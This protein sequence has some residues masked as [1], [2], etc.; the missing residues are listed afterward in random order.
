M[1]DTCPVCGCPDRALLRTAEVARVLNVHQR[2]VRR[3]CRDGRLD[4]LRDRHWR[5]RHESL[6]D[7][8]DLVTEESVAP[9]P[10]SPA[11]LEPEW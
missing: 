3:M 11:A 4:G 7:H 2:T 6:H 9:P 8:L 10:P 5:V 1:T